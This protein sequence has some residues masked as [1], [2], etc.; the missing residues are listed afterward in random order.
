MIILDLKNEIY[1]GFF[2]SLD[3]GAEQKFIFCCCL[4]PENQSCI[5]KY[6][7]NLPKYILKTTK[8]NGFVIQ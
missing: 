6:K 1:D 3:P 7:L 8:C 4:Q 2:L 5:L